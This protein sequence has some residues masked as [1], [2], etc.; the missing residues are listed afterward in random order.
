MERQR[1][2]SSDGCGEAESEQDAEHAAERDEA[3]TEAD[4]EDDA[5]GPERDGEGV[6]NRL[7]RG[8]EPAVRECGGDEGAPGGRPP[9]VRD[10]VERSDEAD[11]SGHEFGRGHARD[12][13]RGRGG[14]DG[15]REATDVHSRRFSAG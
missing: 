13:G 11:R 3:E 2:E 1:H 4:E 5:P 15:E 12:D 10:E 9:R 14:D 6:A 8:A 7:Q